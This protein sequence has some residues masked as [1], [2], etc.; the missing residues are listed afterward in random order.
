PVS[1]TAAFHS[2]TP[3]YTHL[4][5]ELSTIQPIFSLYKGCRDGKIRTAQMKKKNSRALRKRFRYNATAKQGCPV[6]G[7]S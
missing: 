4:T 6:R 2:K 7:V 3:L 5:T 1:L